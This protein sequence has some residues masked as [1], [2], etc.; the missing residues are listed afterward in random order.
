MKSA[1]TTFEIVDTLK[2]LDRPSVA[3]IADHVGSKKYGLRLPGTLVTLVFVVKES[4]RYRLGVRFLG[5]IAMHG[6][7]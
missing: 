4:D 1:A 5:T 7:T 2:T 3:G 6:R